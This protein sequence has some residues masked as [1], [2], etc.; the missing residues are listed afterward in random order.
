MNDYVIFTDSA[1]DISAAVLESWGARFCSLQFKFDGDDTLYS[2]NDLDA[3]VFYARMR[4]GGVAKTSAINSETFRIAFEAALKE[5]KDVLY[6]GFSSA[7]SATY[8]AGRIAAEELRE[9][10]PERRLLSVDSLSGSAGE[11][12]L[13]YL[14]VK[15][16]EKGKSI[17]EVAAFAEQ[18]RTKI[19]HVVTVND[20]VYLKRGGRISPTV[21]FVGNAL[22]LKPMIYVTEEGKLET[23]AKAR[24]R[25]KAM[26]TMVERYGALAE[27]AA[28]G[29]VFISHAACADEARALA[30]TLKAT[31]GVSVA[32]VTDIGPVIG[33]HVGPGGLVLL[34]VGKSRV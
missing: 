12:L 13:V 32:L 33:A 19:C 25:K 27:D 11:G 15:E 14:A 1:C 4:A 26:A 24:G 30:D 3:D 28:N 31:Y 18:M 8:T 16:K 10:Y 9:A 29:T 17:E 23:F 7:L 2:N 22:G 5:G 6:I 21:A 20:L 34:F